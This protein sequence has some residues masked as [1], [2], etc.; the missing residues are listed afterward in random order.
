MPVHHGLA[1]LIGLTTGLAYLIGAYAETAAVPEAVRQA[2]NTYITKA[3][4]EAPIRFL[5]SDLLEGNSSRSFVQVLFLVVL[6]FAARR[7]RQSASALAC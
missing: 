2:G 7:G 3:T 4:L 1:R 5:S 6:A